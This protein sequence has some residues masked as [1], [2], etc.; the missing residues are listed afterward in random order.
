MAGTSTTDVIGTFD[1]KKGVMGVGNFMVPSKVK[2]PLHR[3]E[4]C[5][6]GSKR[7]K[8]KKG[9]DKH[10]AYEKGMKVVVDMLEKDS[11]S[12]SPTSGKKKIF[13]RLKRIS[14]GVKSMDDVKA[15]EAKIEK[16]KSKI[17]SRFSKS[18]YS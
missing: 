1:P 2:V 17:E 4:V 8:D 5:N 18:S 9:R 13:S 3:W 15:V 10:Y 16:E 6:G 7:K 14:K 12:G 11:N